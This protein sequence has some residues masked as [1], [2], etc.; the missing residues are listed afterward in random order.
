MQGSVK[1]RNDEKACK[2]GKPNQLLVNS[3]AGP[4][5]V[6]T[7]VGSF[8]R[9]ARILPVKDLAGTPNVGTVKIGWSNAAS[10]QPLALAAGSAPIVYEAPVG[11][12]HD[13][14]DLWFV[15]ANAGDGLVILWS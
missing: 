4:T 5:Q 10:S 13:L 8:F 3:A 7:T 1:L 15:V 6:T 11:A 9:I 12:T 2:Y 14:S